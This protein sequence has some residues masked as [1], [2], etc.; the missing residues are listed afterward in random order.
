MMQKIFLCPVIAAALLASAPGAPAAGLEKVE[1][2]YPDS[3]IRE[4][5][6]VTRTNKGGSL[7]DSTYTEFH[8]N[9]KKKRVVHY[10]NN[11]ETGLSVTWYENGARESECRYENGELEGVKSVWHP[12]GKPKSRTIWKSGVQSGRYESWFSNGNPRTQGSYVNGKVDGEFRTWYDNGRVRSLV[13]FKNGTLY[14]AV[15][16]WHKG[17]ELAVSGCYNEN[18]QPD[19]LWQIYR[20]DGKKCAEIEYRG[21]QQVKKKYFA[22]DSVIDKIF[23]TIAEPK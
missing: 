11:R 3:S 1:T 4:R 23:E 9:G 18:G 7:R 10:H 19:F 21:G 17:G 16:G 12:G 14:G 15:K 5:Y 6:F 2:F 22:P 20:S 8:R 13:F